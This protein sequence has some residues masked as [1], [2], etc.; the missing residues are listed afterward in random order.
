LASSANQAP[1]LGPD[2]A[3]V[4]EVTV[5]GRQGKK[6]EK[7]DVVQQAKERK[8][9]LKAEQHIDVRAVMEKQAKKLAT[10]LILYTGTP[11]E[12]FKK[13]LIAFHGTQEEFE[14]T[15][16]QHNMEQSQS[17]QMGAGIYATPKK[18]EA[19]GYGGYLIECHINTNAKLL[20]LH[21]RAVAL[22]L[23]AEGVKPDEWAGANPRAVVKFGLT[24]YLIK[25]NEV[26][27][28]EG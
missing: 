17:A 9:K 26:D 16:M 25:T 20:D 1:I 4:E 2:I 3:S 6:T 12:D 27:F 22:K 7:V 11:S 21:D 13:T 8:A 15:F 18:S 10:P 5:S 28:R 14:T 19:E 23:R 24:Y